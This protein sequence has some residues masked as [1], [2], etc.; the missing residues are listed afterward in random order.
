[1]RA[2]T[3]IATPPATIRSEVL[4]PPWTKKRAKGRTSPKIPQHPGIQ[5]GRREHSDQ[6]DYLECLTHQRVA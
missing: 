4:D 3:R 2:G 6:G 1:M 5:N